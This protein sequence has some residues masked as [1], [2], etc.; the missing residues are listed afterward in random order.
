MSFRIWIKTL[1]VRKTNFKIIIPKEVG[2][3]E[4][5][6]NDSIIYDISMVRF[7]IGLIKAQCIINMNCV[8]IVLSAHDYKNCAINVIQNFRKYLALFTFKI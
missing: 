6:V 8:N 5:L 3:Y 1:D 4:S 7:L 2:W